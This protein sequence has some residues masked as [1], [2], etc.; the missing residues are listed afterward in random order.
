MA[1]SS[2]GGSLIDDAKLKQL[3]A[4]ML[5]CRLL[6]EHARSQRTQRSSTLFMLRWARRRLLPDAPSICGPRTRSPLAPHDSIASLVKGV[7]L[8][9]IV[10]QLYARRSNTGWR[11][12]QHHQPCIGSG[13]ATP[14]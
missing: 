12:V 8:S 1:G 3:Y 14:G 10:A 11:G 13:W 6:T 2:T 4:T 7:A 9:D 5:Q